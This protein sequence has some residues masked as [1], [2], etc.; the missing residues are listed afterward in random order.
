MSD[1]LHVGVAAK[2]DGDD[3]PVDL[4]RLEEGDRLLRGRDVIIGLARDGRTAF[5]CSLDLVKSENPPK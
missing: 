2:I 3:L 4:A 1:L 5:A